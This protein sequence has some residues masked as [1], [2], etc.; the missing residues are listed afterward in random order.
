MSSSLLFS[1][2]S[3][4]LSFLLVSSLLPSPLLRCRD[5]FSLRSA[6]TSSGLLPPGAVLCSGSWEDDPTAH[7]LARLQDGL[8][9]A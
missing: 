8:G 9:D 6:E 1:S 7:S 3:S 2:V 5:V 4:G